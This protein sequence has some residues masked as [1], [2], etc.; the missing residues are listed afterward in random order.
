PPFEIKEDRFSTAGLEQIGRY[1]SMLL[2][3]QGE[4][5]TVSITTQ[6]FDFPVTL[7]RSKREQTVAIVLVTKEEHQERAIRAF[8]ERQA[9]EALG[10]YAP[11][12]L[13]AA[14]SVRGLTYPLP[15][16][17]ARAVSLT[18]ELLRSVYGLSDE[19][20]LDFRCYEMENR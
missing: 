16:D 7:Y 12:D 11:S 19:A 3:W 17:L 4:L 1:V 8:F 9:I 14:D 18:T 20:G 15:S 2:Q 6:S 5:F 10:D 13:G